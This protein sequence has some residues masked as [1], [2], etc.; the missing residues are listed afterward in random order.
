MSST[1]RFPSQA[2]LLISCTLPLVTIAQQ[3]AGSFHERTASHISF[4]QS[5]PPDF[6]MPDIWER[7]GAGPI[8]IPSFAPVWLKSSFGWNRPLI[9][10]L[11]QPK[12][13]PAGF[14]SG[15]KPRSA[16]AKRPALGRPN[17]CIPPPQVGFRVALM[18]TSTAPTH[19]MENHGPDYR[20]NSITE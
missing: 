14:E 18:G 12:L 10:V 6:P 11:F 17:H 13:Y 1:M 16:S 8:D 9:L 15:L 4:Q 20:R 2:P 3:P 19:A 7:Q 5:C